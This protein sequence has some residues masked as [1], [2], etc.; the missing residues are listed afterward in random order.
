M[1]LDISKPRGFQRFDQFARAV[2]GHLQRALD[3]ARA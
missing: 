2:L 3:L 1:P